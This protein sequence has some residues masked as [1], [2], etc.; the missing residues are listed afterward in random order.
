MCCSQRSTFFRGVIFVCSSPCHS[1]EVPKTACKKCICKVKRESHF[2]S[3]EHWKQKKA[4][5]RKYLHNNVSISKSNQFEN[6]ARN[7]D[8]KFGDGT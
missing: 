7:L 6:K 5:R 2:N 3:G 1:E 8:K 4:L